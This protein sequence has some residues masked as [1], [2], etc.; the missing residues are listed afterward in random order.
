MIYLKEIQ[1][2]SSLK[3]GS[4][5]LPAL[6]LTGLLATLAGCGVAQS[7]PSG[8]MA[9][10]ASMQGH[11]EG[12][13]G[14][15]AARMQERMSQRMA[16]RMT[17]LKTKLQIAPTQEAAWTTFTTAMQPM[18]SAAYAGM[19]ASHEALSK[20]PTPERLD[21]MRALHN[22]HMAE[23]STRMT[24]RADATKAFYNVL[25][26]EQKKTFDDEFSRAMHGGPGMHMMSGAEGMGPGKGHGSMDGHRMNR[27][28]DQRS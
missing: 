4:R 1:M 12:M 8:V 6:L 14:H 24:Q 20:L 9:S 18:Q 13:R 22:Q 2:T 28:N 23:M 21:R 25:S 26:P 3:R 19:R 16:E 27:H 7:A 15:D 5:A 11:G 17:A 10:P